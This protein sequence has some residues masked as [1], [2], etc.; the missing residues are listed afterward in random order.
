M[1]TYQ[2][3]NE[4]KQQLK[5]DITSDNIC[6]WCYIGKRRLEK[7]LSQINSSDINVSISWYPFALDPNLPRDGS[8][9]KMDRYK[10][11]FGEAFIK[12]RLPQMI[13][14]GKQEGIDFS[15]G[16]KIGSTFDSHRLLYYVKQQENGEKKQNDLINVLFRAY[17]EQEQDL[18]DHQVLIQA[19]QQ[20]GFDS[21]KI[22][23]FLQSDQ[24]KKEVEQEINRSQQEGISGVP[25][26]RINDRIELSGAQDPQQFIQ[27]FRKVGLHI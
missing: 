2:T 8:L 1:S 4:N 5:I 21:N 22:K 14:T 18:S 17:F 26:F 20:I 27:A 16:G 10:Q 3:T 9:M 7:A 12:Q 24:Y 11:K 6:P 23:D 15:F 25:H 19:A 13:E